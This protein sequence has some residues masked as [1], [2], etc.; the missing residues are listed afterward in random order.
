MP[1]LRVNSGTGETVSQ[2]TQLLKN[3]RFPTGLRESAID[4]SG[5][6][7]ILRLILE[8]NFSAGGVK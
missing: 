2:M 5:G 8:D 6:R 4:V 3:R 7:S 1:V